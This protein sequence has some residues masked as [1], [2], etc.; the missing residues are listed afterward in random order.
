MEQSAEPRRALSANRKAE[1]TAAKMRARAY[2]NGKN[3]L[4]MYE[5]E[6]KR[7]RKKRV[8]R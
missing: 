2:E 5:A 1:K 3:L 4:A 6:E 8:K 7:T